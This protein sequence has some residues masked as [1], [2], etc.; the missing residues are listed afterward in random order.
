MIEVSAPRGQPQARRKKALFCV[1]VEPSHARDHQCVV[2][3]VHC[4][5]EFLY[6]SSLKC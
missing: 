6:D 2:V 1:N 4:V 3:F 5:R